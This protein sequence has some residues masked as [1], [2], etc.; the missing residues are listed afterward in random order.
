MIP[1]LVQNILPN[2]PP[3]KVSLLATTPKPRSVKLAISAHGEDPFLLEGVC[4]EATHYVVKVEIGGIAGIVAPLV[5]KQS[6]IRTF[7]LWLVRP[8]CSSI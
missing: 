5:G 8:Q 6:P 2:A 7:G 1:T 4:H 3:V